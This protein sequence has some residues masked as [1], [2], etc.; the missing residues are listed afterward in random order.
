MGDRPS[1]IAESL[2][3]QRGAWSTLLSG[4]GSDGS[5]VTG[6][7]GHLTKVGD[8]GPNPGNLRAF[9]HL[10]DGL[11][12]GAPLVV[13]LHGCHQTAAGYDYGAGWSTLAE[14][15]GF[16]LLLPE[17]KRENNRNGCFNWFEP[18]HTTRDRGE[19]LSIRRMVE[20]LI[21]DHALDWDRVF[22]TGLSAGGAM[23]AA[24][25]ATCPDVFAGGAILAGLPY[26]AATN[27]HEAMDGMFQSRRRP[28]WVWGDLVRA[29]SPH[30]GPWPRVSIWHGTS[31]TTVNPANA[32][33]LVKQWTDV[34]DLGETP[35]V[36][37]RIG[38]H[39][40]RVWRR[41]D[42]GEDL[43]EAYT[44]V[45]MAH[46]VPL[47]LTH[48]EEG[49][50]AVAPFFFDA[51]IS[52]SYLIARFWGLTER[53]QE[54]MEAPEAVAAATTGIEPTPAPA[55]AEEQELASVVVEPESAA[56]GSAAEPTPVP[57]APVDAA[58]GPGPRLKALLAKG[59]RLL[60]RR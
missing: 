3:W 6:W 37:A 2:A 18:E 58:V 54:E 1:P 4:L 41:F 35:T 44:V 9:A 56:A 24:L 51:G 28:A 27:L 38:G 30:Q 22:V 46:G 36:E 32:A 20:R 53:R 40:R 8:F 17:Q 5:A 16:A 14:R 52:S 49:C 43:V 29:A 25:L 57:A 42:D 12:P 34:H 26:R 59:L 10:P 48:G 45:G 60:R 7:G 13:V 21:R 50:G 23:T 31:D 47:A 55:P 19:V 33:E 39:L 15:F 11:P